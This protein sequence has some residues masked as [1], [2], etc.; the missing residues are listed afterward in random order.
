[1]RLTG[2]TIL[3]TGGSAG[4]GLALAKAFIESGNK[5]LIC[6][7]TQAA[8]DSAEQ[9]L[10][11]LLTYRCDISDREQRKTMYD[12]IK[13]DGFQVNILVNNAAVVSVHDLSNTDT[14]TMSAIKSEIAINF[15]AP[16]ELISEWLGHLKRQPNAAIINVNS[17][18]ALVSIAKTP[19][20]SAAKAGL[21]SYSRSLRYHLIK[22]NIRVVDVFPPGVQ[23]QMT[24][25]VETGRKQMSTD[26]FARKLIVEL[27]KDK[28]EIWIGESKI[29][30]F[31]AH[32][33]ARWLFNWANSQLSMDSKHSAELQKPGI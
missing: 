12:A 3:I 16:I 9:E 13:S 11:E 8:L 27:G 7:R 20:Y 6:A 29:I 24:H 15:T 5:V 18:A 28:N 23:T 10:P 32:F 1:M 25:V 31:L 21:L 4:I 33:S 26:E 30:R 19:A 14:S 2:N 17:P 22:D